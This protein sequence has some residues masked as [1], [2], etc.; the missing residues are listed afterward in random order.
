MLCVDGLRLLQTVWELLFST[1]QALQ[2]SGKSPNAE[3]RCLMAAER[4]GGLCHTVHKERG[5]EE[6]KVEQSNTLTQFWWFVLYSDVS[7]TKAQCDVKTQL[8]S[9]SRADL[10]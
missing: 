9:C 6:R 10:Y 2:S 5:E 8:C 1:K 7:E 4:E 3:P